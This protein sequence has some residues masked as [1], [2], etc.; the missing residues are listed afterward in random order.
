MRRRRRRMRRRHYR[1][2]SRASR[3][4][5]RTILMIGAA[6]V[7]GFGIIFLVPPIRRSVLSFSPL[8]SVQSLW[9]SWIDPDKDIVLDA[10]SPSSTDINPLADGN[11]ETGGSATPFSV[12]S[13]VDQN[14]ISR[15]QPLISMQP[16]Y[17][18]DMVLSETASQITVS[19]QIYFTNK[20]TEALRDIALLW[21]EA[22]SALSV[23]SIILNEQNVT[24]LMQSGQ[25]RLYSIPLTEP[26]APEAEGR[27]T[28]IYT[29]I[30]PESK[31][32]PGTNGRS[33][34]IANCMPLLAPY[35]GTQWLEDDLSRFGNVAEFLAT[36]QVPAQVEFDIAASGKGVEVAQ[37]H[38]NMITTQYEL[39]NS[40]T[41]AMAVGSSMR[42]Q[43]V[44]VENSSLYFYVYHTSQANTW[45]ENTQPL[46]TYMRDTF[47]DADN[48]IHVFETDLAEDS[49][50][51]GDIIF[52]N[53]EIVDSQRRNADR[54]LAP[55]LANIWLN[56][57]AKQNPALAELFARYAAQ[58]YLYPDEFESL[59]QQSANPDSINADLIGAQQEAEIN[60]ETSIENGVSSN[61][62]GEPDASTQAGHENNASLTSATLSSQNHIDQDVASLIMI[63]AQL[64]AETFDTAL[65]EYIQNHGAKPF[66]E[67]FDERVRNNIDILMQ[68]YMDSQ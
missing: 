20:H 67:Y 12:H 45:A 65:K 53:Q 10:A 52:V 46:L 22:E 34:A 23:D 27:M 28:L 42:T 29:L 1:A 33:R 63:R 3:R 35:N 38:E 57:S 14:P 31:T 66:T 61:A 6:V 8:K 48:P 43:T 55:H 7:V 56:S 49:I 51:F 16:R 40:P 36:I 11:T 5:R 19:Q 30:L 4:N 60:G 9:Q 44:T 2:S 64:G 25:G 68:L 24:S 21:P 58:R 39:K 32:V 59:M 41:Y 54:I 18:M 26:I 50:Q 62:P 17:A 37:T 15:P 13:A 47:G